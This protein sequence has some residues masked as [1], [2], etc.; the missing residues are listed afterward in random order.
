LG[1][2]AGGVFSVEDERAGGEERDEFGVEIAVGG[3]AVE[4]GNFVASGG[5]EG[6]A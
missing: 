2:G 6:G 3:G 4:L 1:G 5:A